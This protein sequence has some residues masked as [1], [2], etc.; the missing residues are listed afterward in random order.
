MTINDIPSLRNPIELTNLAS[1]VSSKRSDS[2]DLP[3]FIAFITGAIFSKSYQF[4]IARD[5]GYRV[6]VIDSIRSG[7]RELAKEGLI[8]LF[9]PLELSEKPET[10]AEQ[11]LACLRDL[12]EKVV[13]VVT[14]MEM[15]VYTTSLVAKSMGLPGLPPE[16]VVKARE[17]DRLREAMKYAGLPNVKCFAIKARTEILRAVS[18]VGFPSVLKP[19]IGADSL[20]VKRLDDLVD[21][22]KA[23]LESVDVVSRLEV[24]SGYLTASDC[25]KSKS[26]LPVE[27][28]LEEYLEGPEVDVDIV[29][30]NGNSFYCGLSDNGPTKEPYFTET[31]GLF[32]S[33]LPQRD[34]DALTSLSLECLKT[35]GFTHGVFHVEAKLTSAGPRIIEVNA[36]MGGGPI[37]E[38]HLHVR[39]V[40]LCLEQLRIISS[41]SGPDYE[42]IQ[43]GIC[44]DET[45]GSKNFAYM[46][47]NAIRSGV[48]GSDMSFLKDYEKRENLIGISSRVKPGDV[49]IG[50]E[51]GQPSWLVEICM[52]S[53]SSC[54]LGLLVEEICILSELIATE[55]CRRYYCIESA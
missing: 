21:L 55:F 19:V 40:D 12:G 13:G 20:G 11:C 54:C 7:G 30:K 6:V 5:M 2:G 41:C 38:M 8:D 27:F 32:P 1:D 42:E 47:T 53:S 14:F 39:G 9:S 44:D 22:E 29:L 52:Q 4:K 18:E 46:T 15:A 16:S 28:L 48:V 37:R 49:V 43:V 3:G 45:V 35:L 23:Y 10:A 25:V 33:L 50:P 24:S 36:R 31:Y 26:L 17:K 51:K 34:Q